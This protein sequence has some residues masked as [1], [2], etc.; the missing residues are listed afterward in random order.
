VVK[1]LTAPGK[2]LYSRQNGTRKSTENLPYIDESTAR[3]RNE[4]EE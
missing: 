1:H 2:W 3:L 4:A